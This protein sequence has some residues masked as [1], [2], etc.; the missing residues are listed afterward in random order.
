MPEEFEHGQFQNIKND[1][2]KKLIEERQANE[3]TNVNTSQEGICYFCFKKD[4][5][6]A[7]IVDICYDC[8]S[9]KGMEPILTIV[10]RIPYGYCYDHGGYCKLKYANNLAQ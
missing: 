2:G 10:K 1:V 3:F 7:T 8:A 6:S 5:V 4:Y 9:K